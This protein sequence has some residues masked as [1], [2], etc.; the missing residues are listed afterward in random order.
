LLFAFCVLGT[1]TLSFSTVAAA[2]TKAGLCENCSTDWSYNQRAKIISNEYTDTVYIL[3]YDQQ[4]IK[5]FNVHSIPAEPGMPAQIVVY[6]E[7]V[8]SSINTAFNN[9]ANA[10][11]QMGG[12]FTDFT[13]PED[14][15]TSAYQLVGREYLVNDLLD[16]FSSQNHGIVGRVVDTGLVLATMIG[17]LNINRIYTLKFQNGDKI[18]IKIVGVKGDTVVPTFEFQVV[19]VI[20]QDNNPVSF[21]P[22]GYVSGEKSFMRGGEQALEE[23]IKA[24]AM[25]G[26]TIHS[27]GYHPRVKIIDCEEGSPEKGKCVEPSTPTTIPY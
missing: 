16:R 2:S 6:E 22:N 4:K 26:I 1:L 23:F 18:K 17:K 7:A 25:M 13:V 12:L 24:A 14:I 10:L 9:H 20:D 27:D 21:Q 8:E 11:A 5:K 15:A 19:S 3:S